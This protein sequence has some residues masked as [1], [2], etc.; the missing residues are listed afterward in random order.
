[1]GAKAAL[2][3]VVLLHSD[4]EAFADWKVATSLSA[5][6]EPYVGSQLFIQSVALGLT[7]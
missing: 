3:P 4:T 2:S 5:N 6:Y 1:M 7:F